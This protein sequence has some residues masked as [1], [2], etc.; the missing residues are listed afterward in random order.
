MANAKTAA[1]V[2]GILFIIAGVLGY[3]PNP[4]V[5][6]TG[7]FQVNG[8]HNIFHIGAGIVLL[9]G[10]YAS[11][12]AFGPGF[13]LRF[14]GAVYAL[15][16]VLGFLMPGNA[17]LGALAMNMADHWLHAVLAVVILLAGFVLAPAPR[18]ANA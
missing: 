16:A 18:T 11:A 14:V 1:T 5:S 4:I 3:V 17:I 7:I 12:G 10:A 6:P 13:A 9:L 15:L 2:F 8:Y